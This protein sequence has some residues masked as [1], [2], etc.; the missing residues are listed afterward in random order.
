[1]NRI[2]QMFHEAQDAG[3]KILSVFVTAGYPTLESTADIVWRL[4]QSGADLVEIGIPFSDPI[5]DGPT[6]QNSSKIALDNGM[7]VR[8][9]LKQVRTIRQKS[10]IP[11][12]LMGYLNPLLKYGLETFL[13]DAESAGVDGLII[14]DLLPEEFYRL[15]ATFDD[16]SLGLS[17]LVSPNT[18]PER[19]KKIDKLTS[20]FIYCVSVTGVTGSRAGLSSTLLGFLQSLESIVSHPRLVGFGISNAGNAKN[21]AKTVEGVIVGSAVIDLMTNHKDSQQMLKTIGQFVH[22]LKLAV[23][24][25]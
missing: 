25:L 12:I 9:A 6:I 10:E 17:F 14:P 13:C 21:I 2:A 16:S 20:H 3:D 15:K 23:R 22:T 18:P 11:L 7:T 1:M 24:G 4:D 19:I 8:L 5:A